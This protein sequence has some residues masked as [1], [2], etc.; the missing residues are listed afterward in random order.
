M[1]TPL[2]RL[3]SRGHR[4]ALA[5]IAFAVLGGSALVTAGAVLTE[6]GLRADVPPTCLADAQ[7][8]VSASQRV[9]VV[10]D[11][12]VRLPERTPVP[13]DLT[14]RIEQVPGVTAAAA[15]VTVPVTVGF[16]GAGHSVEAHPW[17]VAALGDPALRGT[18]PEPGSVVLDEDLA[19]ATGLDVGDA[20]TLAGVSTP[21]T[22]RVAGIVD[23][24]GAAAH[25]DPAT[26]ASLGS[27]P[28][29]QADLIAV[30]LEDDA[31]VTAVA[32]AIDAAVDGDLEVTT[33]D[34]RGTVESLAV[35]TARAEL[36]ELSAA[37]A[38]TLLLLVGCIVASA[39]S[40]TVANQRRELALLRAVG[41]TP[42]Q[43]RSLVAR[44]ATVATAAGLVPG[45]LLGYLLAGW[46]G[47]QLEQRGVLPIDL[48]VTY[49]PIA[50]LVV[51]AVT[52]A[53][54]HLAARAV[55]LRASRR[56]A[57]EAVSESAVEPRH[58]SK[59]RTGLGLGLIALSLAPAFG[60]LAFTG[61]S[62]FVSAVSGTLVGIVGLALAGPALARAVTGALARAVGDRTP[63]TSWLALHQT[64]AYS[65]RTAG[66]V[67]VLALAFSLTVAQVYSQSTLERAVAAEQ[68]AGNVADARV[69]GPLT[70]ADV[71][72]LAA[73]PGVEDAVPL[74][75]TSVVRT[76]RMLGDETTELSSALAVGPGAD[77]VLDLDVAAGDLA[78]LRGD[79]IAVDA[80]AARRWKVEV[81]DRLDLR[82]ANGAAVSPRVVS[83]YERALGFGAVVASTD[84]LQDQGLARSYDTVLANGNISAL[85]AWADSR[86]GHQVATTLV[87]DAGVD[88]QRWINL[89]VL[90]P[91]LGYVL[92]AVAAS[93][94]TTTRRRREELATLRALGATPRQVRALVTREAGLL[95]ALA[96]AAGAVLAVLPMSV[97]GLGVLDR[98]WPQGPWW[99]IPTIAVVVVAVAVGAMRGAAR[100]A[101]A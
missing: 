84:L 30:R 94:R 81:G 67:S 65:L 61:E 97:L 101:M 14:E 71:A 36:L 16:D 46:F 89:I 73:E 4:R 13:A 33:G 79:A 40:T 77:R 5:G 41:A 48:P 9:P 99:V 45:V 88:P 54:V 21:Q 59:V 75:S 19:Q 37:I 51:V 26:L 28:A 64:H 52:L 15:D 55:T 24:P 6:T 20:V 86:P 63:V 92:V 44:Q 57:T 95:A 70:P 18:P 91:M 49:S 85:T 83:T 69:G 17:E 8:L 47:G 74:V 72:D 25:L 2:A 87:A 58:P 32:D 60:S 98:P 42:R 1:S 56:P 12:D 53:M 31:S 93:L 35:G 3:L 68:A 78:D 76:T 29:G 50:G 38:G 80:A 90:L 100:R 34:A 96:V 82:L 27:V 43:V 62:A 11:F 66:A 7:V 22:A 10:E 39:L 23:A